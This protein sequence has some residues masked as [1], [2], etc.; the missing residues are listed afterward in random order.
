MYVT[1][2]WLKKRHFSASEIGKP[3]S[4]CH[5]WRSRWGTLWYRKIAMES[6]PLMHDV[7]MMLPLRNGDFPLRY[8]R[9]PL[10]NSHNYGKSMKI[11]IFNGKIH[12]K[13]PFSIAM[14]VYQRVTSFIHTHCFVHWAT[15]Q[16][17]LSHCDW[18]T[19]W[20]AGKI[21]DGHADYFLTIHWNIVSFQFAV[22]LKMMIFTRD[23]N[24]KIEK[25]PK[26]SN[27]TFNQ[28]IDYNHTIHFLLSCFFCFFRWIY[29]DLSW[30]MIYHPKVKP[31]DSPRYNMIC[32]NLPSMV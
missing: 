28:H 16:I 32:H 6:G 2:P 8:I 29:H 4:A 30:T 13:W 3:W 24:Q 11:T 10:V 12:Y 17:L 25:W 23:V 15:K 21:V 26:G 1:L 7:P 27:L 9:Y 31:M 5:F 19:E 18:T 14:L 20:P 22:W